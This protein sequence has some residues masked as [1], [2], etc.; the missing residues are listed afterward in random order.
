[1]AYKILNFN[2][3]A[4]ASKIGQAT[5]ARMKV[6]EGTLMIRFT[7]RTND[8]NLG[9]DQLLKDLGVKGAGR[10]VGVTSAFSEGLEIGGAV[11]LERSK[12]GWF[13]VVQGDAA[14]LAGIDGR[15]SA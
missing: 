9:D 10:R 1:M 2:A 8:A 14:T 7:D 15:V 4:T 5:K 12:Y 13:R 6:V 3:A 11:S